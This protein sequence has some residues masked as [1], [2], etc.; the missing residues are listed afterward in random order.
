MP[1]VVLADIMIY[2]EEAD[3]LQ[4]IEFA[5]ALYATCAGKDGLTIETLLGSTAAV[6]KV[7]KVALDHKKSANIADSAADDGLKDEDL[8][9]GE[10][11]TVDLMIKIVKA[12]IC[13]QVC[14]VL[15]R[16]FIEHHMLSAVA[17]VSGKDTGATLY[18][19]ADMCVCSNQADDTALAY[20]F[21]SLA[22]A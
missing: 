2:D 21:A 5:Q 1:I 9:A 10:T 12:G 13:L 16:P 22:P 8:K 3:K 14:I 11:L 4:H 15:A 18:G 7:L 6:N 20:E 19:P 17:A